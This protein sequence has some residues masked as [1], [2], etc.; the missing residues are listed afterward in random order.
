[1]SSATIVCLC[2][3]CASRVCAT[4][5]GPPGVLRP[6]CMMPS[7]WIACF[8]CLDLT[9]ARRDTFVASGPLLTGLTLGSSPSLIR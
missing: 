6:C 7:F 8:I 9:A 1:M 3:Y 4:F 5:S 2:R